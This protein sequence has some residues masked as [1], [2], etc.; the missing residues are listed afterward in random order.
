MPIGAMIFCFGCQ[1]RTSTGSLGP[2]RACWYDLP[3]VSGCGGEIVRPG[4]YCDY[5]SAH[6]AGRGPAL[7]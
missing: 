2:L 1:D 5:I 6:S 7:L 3:V 4:G